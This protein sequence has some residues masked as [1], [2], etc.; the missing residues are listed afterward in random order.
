MFTK[1]LRTLLSLDRRM[2]LLLLESFLQLG[3][4][5]LTFRLSFA[6]VAPRLGSK[7]EETPRELDERHI[8]TI[9]RI[10]SAIGIMSRYT[11]WESKCMVQAMAGM[12]MLERRG[13]ASTLY[14]GTARDENGNLIAHAWLRSG[15]HYVSG[16]ETM[17]RFVVVEKFAN[18]AR[19]AG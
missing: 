15:S 5:K 6:K 10:R 19:R 18:H 12:S 3:A 8:G 1:K 4:A 14:M 9:R 13:I 16:F 11:P 2:F 7:N 17:K